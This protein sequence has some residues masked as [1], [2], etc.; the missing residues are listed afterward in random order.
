MG[1]PL[2]DGGVKR[3]HRGIHY[4][5]GVLGRILPIKG[6][7]RCQMGSAFIL[8]RHFSSAGKR[9]KIVQDWLA[10]DH[11]EVLKRVES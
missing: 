6:C 1:S 4:C 8:F 11:P 7:L 10:E 5:F 2:Q 3:S 9:K